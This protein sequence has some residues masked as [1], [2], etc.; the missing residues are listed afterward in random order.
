MDS[1][2]SSTRLPLEALPGP[3]LVFGIVGAVGTDLEMVSDVLGEQLSRVGYRSEEIRLSAL[4]YQLSEYGALDKQYPSEADRM[5]EHMEA[6]SGFRRK[7]KRG[8]I[9]ALMAVGAIRE[10]RASCPNGRADRPVNNTAYVLR[11]LKHPEEVATLRDI[12]GRAFFVISAYAP[13]KTRTHELAMRIARSQGCLNPEDFEDRAKELVKIDEREEG[14]LGQNVGD[15]FPLADLF[16]DVR[17]RES[18]TENVE[19]FVELLFGNSFHSPKKAEYAMFHAFAASLRS[20]DLGRQVGASVADE[21]GELVVVGCNEVP[22]PGGGTYWA[23]DSEHK[24]DRDFRRG[25][26]SSTEFRRRLLAELITSYLDSGGPEQEAKVAEKVDKLFQDDGFKG[27]LAASIIEYGRSVHAEMGAIT[28]ASR[29]GISLAGTT[30]YSTTFP[31]HLCAKHIVS[32]GINRVVYIEPYPKSQVGLLFK[33]SIVV[34]PEGPCEGRVVFEPFVGVSP[35][36]YS[37]LFQP[38]EERKDK[39]GNV[40]EWRAADANPRLR[41]FVLSYLM[42]E[43]DVTGKLLPELFKNSGFNVQ[44]D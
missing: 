8:D 1:D 32:S 34:D 29:R 15:A 9:F 22:A 3:E 26:D 13:R 14:A 43:D 5:K 25:I 6:G 41:R 11:S 7:V 4:L 2:D 31:C 42:I 20:A 24:D 37:W 36:A 18:V 30:L 28:D 21:H 10:R 12:Y 27:T 39:K 38:S 19:R 17:T 33:D 23:D 35:A 40:I 16:V 44:R